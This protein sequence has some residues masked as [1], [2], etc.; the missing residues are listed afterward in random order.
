M[1]TGARGM[2][3]VVRHGPYV[4]VSLGP[5][6]LAHVDG[7][8]KGTFALSAKVLTVDGYWLTRRPHE[9][10]LR[11]GAQDLVWADVH[12]TVSGTRASGVVTAEQ[13]KRLYGVPSS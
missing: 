4:A 1:I 3:G 12:I 10:A 7:E 13:R 5:W 6:S 8:A 11:A 2:S 9:V